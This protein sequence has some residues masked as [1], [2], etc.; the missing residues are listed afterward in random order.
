MNRSFRQ[1]FSPMGILRMLLMG[2]LVGSFFDGFHTHGGATSYPHPVV[3]MMAWWTPLLF[4]PVYA[5]LGILYALGQSRSKRPAPTGREELTLAIF[6]GIY[7]ATGYLATN[8][9][10]LAVALTAG[11]M[12]W[13]LTD[14]TLATVG[15]GLL[16]AVL[17]PA[18]EI[19]FVHIGILSHLHPDLWG[20][21]MW[22][23][24]L[25]FSSA[26][27]A[28]PSFAKLGAASFDSGRVKSHAPSAQD[29]RG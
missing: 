29:E 28:G 10:K 6:G 11:L 23:P 4:G 2:A 22:L 15:V 16:A 7:F 25:Y 12:L 20:I 3:W 17:G 5:L 14:R 21:P 9:L 24:A 1:R 18:T 27:G 13:V 19:F 26:A 8:E